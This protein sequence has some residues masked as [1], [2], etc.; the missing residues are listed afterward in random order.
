MNI[1]AWL[2]STAAGARSIG[3]APS[4]RSQ[5]VARLLKG[6]ATAQLLKEGLHPFSDPRY[7]D[8]RWA[9]QIHDDHAA[10]RRY[11]VDDGLLTRENNTYW[12]SGETFEV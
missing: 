3:L 4:A 1:N 2:G 5:Q 6:A 10:L 12:R 11:L 8:G 9:I 7:R